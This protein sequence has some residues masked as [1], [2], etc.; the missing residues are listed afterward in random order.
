MTE[1][2]KRIPNI[3]RLMDLYSEQDAHRAQGV[4]DELRDRFIANTDEFVASVVGE[5]KKIPT[6]NFGQHIKNV[7]QAI[8]EDNRNSVLWSQLASLEKRRGSW[9]PTHLFFEIAIYL[10]PNNI[11][12]NFDFGNFLKDRGNLDGAEKHYR[13]C[14]EIDDDDFSAH[15]SLG[16]ILVSQDQVD[17]AEHEL[18]RAIEISP[19]YVRA[20]N[21]LAALCFNS[22]RTQEAYELCSKVLKLD[23]N[24]QIAN[25]NLPVII[26]R[27]GQ[28]GP[29]EVKTTDENNHEIQ[30]IDERLWAFASSLLESN[31]DLEQFPPDRIN[32]PKILSSREDVILVNFFQIGPLSS[33]PAE[34][35]P[36]LPDWKAVLIPMLAANP[37]NARLWMIVGQNFIEGQERAP[38]G[39]F[40]EV[41]QRIVKGEEKV[42]DLKER[43]KKA[44]KCWE[45]AL[46]IDP[47]QPVL[48]LRLG[49]AYVQLSDSETNSKKAM[50][51]FK[52][53]VGI[54]PD[55]FQA[56]HGM[57][58]IYEN[59]FDLDKATECYKEALKHN[60]DY[61]PSLVQY[62]FLLGRYNQREKANRF[63]S[64]AGQLD[65]EGK[66][67][68]KAFRRSLYIQSF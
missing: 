68:D 28:D 3:Q 48:L 42:A 21:N 23:P 19:S 58:E 43:Y 66:Y 33:L 11:G 22:G 2:E 38:Q 20:Y 50:R 10:D 65:P 9:G 62:G 54:K 12:A 61:V 40:E 14:V 6:E 29:A 30:S 5:Y 56:W 16:D 55:F 17:E 34:K 59:G 8:G 36:Q 47:Q 7:V 63:L 64:R 35:I 67:Y 53:A 32:M 26:S 51:C 4:I 49:E 52:K 44:T 45:R 60:P 24:N 39:E 41:F 27:L 37:N 57:A 13:K 15:N 25:R 18:R 1:Q 46:A 31:L